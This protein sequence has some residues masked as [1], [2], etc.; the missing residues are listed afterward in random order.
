MLRPECTAGAFAA[1]KLLFMIPVLIAGIASVIVAVIVATGQRKPSRS[2]RDLAHQEADIL[3]KLP[4]GSRAEAELESLI[5]SRI[6]RWRAQSETPAVYELIPKLLLVGGVL[7][8]LGWTLG[9]AL[10]LYFKPQS[11]WSLR[12][13]L[14]P[15]AY[16]LTA[17]GGAL[18][19]IAYVLLWKMH[20]YKSISADK[21]APRSGSADLAT[22]SAMHSSNAQH[23]AVD[24]NPAP[25]A[26]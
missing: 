11:P 23:T 1:P 10:D 16:V 15:A 8:V 2:D 17:C 19:V 5:N 12:Q 24:T 3:K 22:S 20:R 13:S 14:M 4:Q 21:S 25:S 6:V 18:L 26:T 7:G 9:F